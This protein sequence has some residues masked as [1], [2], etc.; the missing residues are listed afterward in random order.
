MQNK[1]AHEQHQQTS[2]VALSGSMMA[3]RSTSLFYEKFNDNKMP[4]AQ[5]QK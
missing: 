1:T 3:Q 2:A 5:N 4:F